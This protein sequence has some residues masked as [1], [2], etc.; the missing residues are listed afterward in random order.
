[1]ALSARAESSEEGEL[2][3]VALC[4]GSVL[5]SGHAFEAAALADDHNDHENDTA[6]DDDQAILCYM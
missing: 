1:M 4:V 5:L 6:H 2:F 3:M